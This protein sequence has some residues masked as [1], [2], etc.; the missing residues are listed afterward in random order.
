MLTTAGLQ[1]PTI[2]LLEIVD[3]IGGVSFRQIEEG[4]V[5]TGLTLFI[6]KI[7]NGNGLAHWPAS[8]VKIYVVVILL[9]TTEGLQDPVIPLVDIVD[10]RGAVP[11]LQIAGNVASKVGSI[12]VL[13]VTDAVL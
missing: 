5:N 3:R 7:V 4:R 10:K 9:F 1:V 11:P 13:T 2:P 8:G 6:T 12:L